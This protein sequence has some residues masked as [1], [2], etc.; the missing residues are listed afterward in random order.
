MH[1]LLALIR[2]GDVN[3]AD[4]LS[5]LHKIANLVAEVSSELYNSSTS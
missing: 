2:I 4:K 3:F 1:Q 5:S